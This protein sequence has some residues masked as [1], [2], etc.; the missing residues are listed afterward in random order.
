MARVPNLKH[1]NDTK[2]RVADHDV[3]RIKN[4]DGDTLL[5]SPQEAK[6][7]LSDY[8][9]KEL[10]LESRVTV[11]RYREQLNDMLKTELQEL[12]TDLDRLVRKEIN[13]MVEKVI[14]SVMEYNIEAEVNRRVEDK[15]DEL[16]KKFRKR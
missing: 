2:R 14:H 5:F 10:S 15:L 13:N 16:L 4:K 12:K 1:I 6:D 8:I 7:V 3:L 9:V 11:D